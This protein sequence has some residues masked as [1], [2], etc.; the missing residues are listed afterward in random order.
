[1]RIAY[2]CADRGVP[3]FGCKGCSIHVQ[4]VV[5]A[6]RQHGH[7]VTI[8]AAR[9]GGTAPED[10]ADV[11]VQRLP[12]APKYDLAQR[13]QVEIAANLDL[14]LALELGGPF[15][16]VYE[17]YS[18]WSFSAMV[19]AQD[20]QIPGVLEVNA[21]LLLEQAQ[22]RQL[23]HTQ[24]AQVIARRV[25]AAAS[26][27]VAVSQDVADY[28]AS[29]SQTQGRVAVVPNGVNPMRFHPSQSGLQHSLHQPFTVGF[30]GTMKDWHGLPVLTQ[31]FMQFYRQYS[32]A[33]LLMVGDGP[34]RPAMQATLEQCGLGEAVT[35]SGRV[36]PEQI[37]AWLAMMDVAVAPYP[38][39]ESFYFSPLKVYEY[40]AAGLPVVASDVGQLRHII[41]SEAN[42]LLCAA[43]DADA[44]T[45]QLQRLHAQPHLRLRLGQAARKTV[46]ACHSWMQRV[47]HILELA[48]MG[49]LTARRE[50]S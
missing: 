8:F 34:A 40:M 10:L 14:R 41:Q 25:F 2:V 48:R 15:D 33:R 27:L 20:Y 29:F 42:G 7:Q 26:T 35:W 24:Q 5:R 12:K 21:P 16:L 49:A 44:L 43:G 3:I 37:P 18:L 1:M 13:E 30:V 32:Q 6:L 46:L 36:P 39:L 17:R 45:A 31:A 4:E 22:Y 23:I 9:L 38:L 11:P 47:A 28:L 19:Y 50:V